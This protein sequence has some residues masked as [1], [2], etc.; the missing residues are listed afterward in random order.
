MWSLSLNE[1]GLSV[2]IVILLMRI[3]D[4]KGYFIVLGGYFAIVGGVSIDSLSARAEKRPGAYL[5]SVQ[6]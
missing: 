5:Q 4:W 3:E 2:G 1:G 6:S